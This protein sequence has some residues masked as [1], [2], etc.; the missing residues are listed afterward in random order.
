VRW[1]PNS[2]PLCGFQTQRE[3]TPMLSEIADCTA[4]EA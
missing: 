2:R 3:L 1:T 4:R